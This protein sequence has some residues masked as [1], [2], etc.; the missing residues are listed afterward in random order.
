MLKQFRRLQKTRSLIIVIFAVIMGLSLVLFYAPGGRDAL[1]TSAMSREVLAR[2]RGDKI[3][4]GDLEGIKNRAR[5][6][7][8]QMPA[9]M[10]RF[11][12]DDMIRSRMVAQE[13]ERL[14]LAPSDAEVNAWIKKQLV[15]PSTNKFIGEADFERYKDYAVGQAGSIER[16]EQSV[17]EQLARQNLEAFVTAGVTVS[18]EE[19]RSEW[20]R[21]NTKFELVYVPVLAK[22]V[23]KNITPT[24][25]EIAAYY[26]A[27]KE[28][29]R[30]NDA[31]KKI[32]Y[33]FI[34][35]SKMG[36]RI[37]VSDDDLRKDYE[38]LTPDRKVAGVRVQ[39]IVLRVP[40]PDQEQATLAK[41]Q[42]IV[43][44]M[45]GEDL[46]A[47]EEKFAEAARG[48]SQDVA[49][50][51]GGGWLAQP[52]KKDAAKKDDIYQNVFDM[53]EGEVK[54]PLVSKDTVYI[55]RRGPDVPKTFETAREELLVSKRHRLAYNDAAALARRAA[56]RLR[57]TKDPSAVARELSQQANMNPT[58]MVKETDYIKPGDDVPGVG[59]NPQFEEAIAPL[60]NA[61]DVGDQV[62]VRDGF[63]IPMLVDK[64]DPRLP[65]LEEVRSQVAE[66][67]KEEKA[68]KQL[69]QAARDLANA[70]TPEELKAAAAR[71]GLSAQTKT[72]YTLS[73]SL[74]V[75]GT[76]PEF[77]EA[78]YKLRAGEVSKSPIKVG[79]TWVVA[80]ASSR[81]DPKPEEFGAQRD[82]LMETALSERRQNVYEDYVAA[83]RARLEKEG[84][85][86]VKDDVLAKLATLEEP[87]IA[88]PI[89]SGAGGGGGG[90]I[91]VPVMPEP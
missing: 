63:A 46:K 20:E 69:E 18:E 76:N 28:D 54:D 29:F 53:Q 91:P 83:L 41:A 12:L 85:I 84:E 23:A 45:R 31:Q 4:V 62:G 61:Q 27:N 73:T 59:S 89:P 10:D 39:Q 86:E 81:N 52:V 50:A 80:A 17:R 3:T 16:F 19:V 74:D 35:T 47:S 21:T 6:F 49:T 71:M 11:L 30:I 48:Q 40:S 58:E 67:A 13:A 75:V 51:K 72:D 88:S 25:E 34:N 43:N 36:E 64:R 32:R 70:S 15:D 77:Q 42:S 56:E 57:E 68:Q 8:Q 33:V 5:R 55:L 14:G 38:A 87:S 82:D 65:S 44:D 1:S 37:K 79:E 22:D 24:D 9:G 2:V 60:N 26:E 66:R 78:V 7:G 90:S